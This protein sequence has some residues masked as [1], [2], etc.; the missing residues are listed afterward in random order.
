MRWPPEAF[1][2]ATLADIHSAV[3]GYLESKGVQ[4]KG[5]KSDMY[6]DLLAMAREARKQER[7]AERAAKAKPA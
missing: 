4:P 3:V 1:W 2:D 5:A 6:D 7:A